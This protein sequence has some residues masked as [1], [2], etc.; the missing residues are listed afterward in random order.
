M[1]YCKH[2]GKTFDDETLTACPKCGEPFEKSSGVS[3]EKY[4]NSGVSLVKEDS[5][6]QTLSMLIENNNASLSE[7]KPSKKKSFLPFAIGIAVIAVIIGVVVSLKS[8]SNADGEYVGLDIDKAISKI[9]KD[10]YVL[11]TIFYEYSDEFKEGKVTYQQESDDG[12]YIDLWV[13]LG[14]LQDDNRASIPASFDDLLFDYPSN[15]YLSELNY[16]DSDVFYN[17]KTYPQNEDFIHIIS[18]SDRAEY[19][20][21]DFMN[22]YYSESESFDNFSGIDSYKTTDLDGCEVITFSFR[23]NRTSDSLPFT[24]TEQIVILED[25]SVDFVYRDYSGDLAA[26]IPKM[27][28]SVR[29]REGREIHEIVSPGYYGMKKD[30]AVAAAQKDGYNISRIVYNLANTE[31]TGYAESLPTGYVIKYDV[32]Y[33]TAADLTLYVRAETPE[34]SEDE[35]DGELQTIAFGNVEATLPKSYYLREEAPDGTHAKYD[36]VSY[37]DFYD[38]IIFRKMSGSLDTYSEEWL[39]ETIGS[40]SNIQNFE[41]VDSYERFSIDGHDAVTYSWKASGFMGSFAETVY[42]VDYG[43]ELSYIGFRDYLSENSGR[44]ENESFKQAQKSIH[45]NK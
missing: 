10:I 41:K 2:C 44:G 32:D 36:S 11:D 16:R 27:A 20:T 5:D 14:K 29:L 37:M 33:G 7:T 26:F 34:K 40:Y 1:A 22:D 18:F 17:F 24:Q 28:P 12:M 9:D 38:N 6:L 43:G 39:N 21:K 3:L 8:A 15:M 25:R 45:I 30:D 13:S 23:A 4:D 31:Y 42:I 19:M 35:L